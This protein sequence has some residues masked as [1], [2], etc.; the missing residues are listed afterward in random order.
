LVAFSP[1]RTGSS[2][3]RPLVVATAL[4]VA[5]ASLALAALFS[6]AACA[7]ADDAGDK[8]TPASAG[9]GQELGLSEDEDLTSGLLRIVERSTSDTIQMC[10]IELGFEWQPRHLSPGSGITS[11]PGDPNSD[12]S[13]AQYAETHGFGVYLAFTGMELGNPNDSEDPNADYLRELSDLE[14]QAWQDGVNGCTRESWVHQ[15]ALFVLVEPFF[16]AEEEALVD[17]DPRLR[18]SSNEFRTAVEG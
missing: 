5:G 9:F 3:A 6:L 15:E 10:M 4:R 13:D 7:Q 18:N 14:R 2:S 16:E 12:L 8:R 1:L 11:R 17:V